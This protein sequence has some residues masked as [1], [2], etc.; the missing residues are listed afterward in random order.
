MDPWLESMRRGDYAAAWRICD[1]VLEQRRGTGF[2]CSRLP[3][4]EQFLWDGR[5]L[6]DRDVLVH[7]YHGL[8][9]TLQFVRLLPLL[10]ARAR[11]TTLWVQ[12]VLLELLRGCA[13]IDRLLPLHDG[14]PPDRFDAHV[15]LMELPHALRLDA[16]LLPGPMPYVHVPHPGRRPRR[17]PRLRVGLAWRAGAWNTSRSIAA[18][19]LAPLAAVPHVAW[20]AVQWGERPPA[21]AA[22]RACADLV[23]QARRLQSLDVVVTVDTMTAHLAGALALPTWTLLPLEHDWRWPADRATTAWYPTMRLF[24]QSAPGDWERVLATVARE[25]AQR[26]EEFTVC[27]NVTA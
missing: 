4:H 26:G 6:D 13:G 8:G 24:H 12:P 14:A 27:G 25:L 18:E 21:F 23:E 11:R 15:E 5:P 7:C 10:R 3:R 16:S 20:F 22:D 17:D 9:D 2:D 1:R 19:R